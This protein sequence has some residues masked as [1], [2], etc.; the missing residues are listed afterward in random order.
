MGAV[1]LDAE[2]EGAPAERVAWV[3]Y[4]LPEGGKVW[5]C[6]PP[7]ELPGMPEEADPK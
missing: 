1:W 7:P 5:V 6:E 4:A 3:A 2:A